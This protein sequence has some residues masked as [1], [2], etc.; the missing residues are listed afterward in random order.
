MS[1][2]KIVFVDDE[3]NILFALKRTLYKMHETWEMAFFDSAK[4]A[5]EYMHQNE[6]HFLVT[7][8]RMPEM[9]GL[10]L[11][12][13]SYEHFPKMVRI[14]LSGQTSKKDIIQSVGLAHQF[15]SKPTDTEQLIDLIERITLVRGIL[16]NNDLVE[17]IT[18]MKSL[19]TLPALYIQLRE[20]L[21]DKESSMKDIAL[22]I[23]GDIG[24]CSKIL[25]LVNSSFFVVVKRV[26]DIQQAISLL[27]IDTIRDLMLS[28][29][30]FEQVNSELLTQF[31]LNELWIH[32]LSV[33]TIA[34]YIAHDLSLS[35]AD[36]DACYI[37]GL[38]HDIGRLVL[39]KQLPQ[40]YIDVLHL[41][42]DKGL[43]ISAAEFNVFGISHSEIAAYLSSIWGFSQSVIMSV[44]LHHNP[45]LFNDRTISV[46]FVVHLANYIHHVSQ[47]VKNLKYFID[48]DK[49]ELDKE[50]V[51]ELGLQEKLN[52][53][54]EYFNANPVKVDN[55]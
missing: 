30:L 13:Y 35:K 34:K 29:H 55:L 49:T 42:K 22:L 43:S 32:S 1:K 45:A 11:L 36:S 14:I 47:S 21:N 4:K 28:I 44:F 3:V 9:S 37:A 19:P 41:T 50:L 39:V 33:A 40:S 10:E 24:L 48:I 46:A 54:I 15:F 23:S 16:N 2:I 7:D 27:G 5:I 17:V 53:Y 26:T 6:V 20:M 18:N 25:Q 12:K 31:H 8:M 52:E 51:N 38:L